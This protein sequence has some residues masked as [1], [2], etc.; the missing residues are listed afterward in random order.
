MLQVS[1]TLSLRRALM[2][3]SGASW[4]F[5]YLMPIGNLSENAHAFNDAPP[6]A[7]P[8]H[9][10]AVGSPWSGDN[11]NVACCRRSC[12]RALIS[13]LLPLGGCAG[14]NI[15]PPHLEP[16]QKCPRLWGLFGYP[17]FWFRPISISLKWPFS[18]LE[19]T[20]ELRLE[21]AHATLVP[22]WS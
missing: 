12:P 5:S 3:Q 1:L 8:P 15:L 16:D 20:L 17:G 10:C 11:G 19:G 22:A 7:S 4:V 18:P 14:D 6:F 21:G 2:E 13:I 9:S